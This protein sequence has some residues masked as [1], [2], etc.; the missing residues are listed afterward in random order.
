MAQSAITKAS[1]DAAAAR[2]AAGTNNSNPVTSSSGIRSDNG[3]TGAD[4]RGLRSAYDNDNAVLQQEQAALADRRTQA[5]KDI[6]TQGDIDAGALET[7]QAGDYAAR[8][9][10]LVTSGGGFLGATQSQQGVLQNLKDTFQTEKTALFAKREAAISAAEQ[11]YEDKDFDLA[12]EMSQNAK[13]LQSEIYK[14]QTDFANQQLQVAAAN[15]AQTEF[16]MGVT[17]KK[18]ASYAAMDDATFAAQNPADIASADAAYYP[19]YTANA[20]A[21]AKKAQDIKTSKDAVDLDSTILDMRLKIPKGQTFT[22]NGQSYTGLKQADGPSTA[23]TT[24]AM[25]NDIA[26]IVMDFQ[27]QIAAKGWAGVDPTAYNYYRDQLANL[28]GASAALALDKELKALDL[29]VDYGN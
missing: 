28:Y 9:T 14:R 23:E 19:G 25:N 7:S 4:I 29:S 22:L 26:S 17:D 1:V 6:N 24:Q 13:D 11:A 5:I 12:K 8:S 2:Y 16:D 20:R 27:K 21:V 15:R 18:V 3:A 10:S